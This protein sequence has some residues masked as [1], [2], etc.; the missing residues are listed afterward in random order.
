MTHRGLVILK[1]VGAQS[2]RT[3]AWETMAG[4][5]IVEQ[6][7]MVSL[8]HGPE[9]PKRNYLTPEVTLTAVNS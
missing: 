9:A 8:L 2:Q 3:Q 5:S 1:W 4:I 7:E 6:G